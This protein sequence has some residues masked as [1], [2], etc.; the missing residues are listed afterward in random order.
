[1]ASRLPREYH[2]VQSANMIYQ[3]CAD[4]ILRLQKAN[5]PWSLDNPSNSYFWDLPCII[6]VIRAS[7][8]TEVKFQ[9][10]MFGSDLPKWTTMWVSPAGMFDHLRQA[11][12]GQH[13][14][15]P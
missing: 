8:A 5:I 7:P 15:A 6:R 9:N 10:C 1:M 4:S 3:A 12:D 13:Q 2:R 14:H 11:C